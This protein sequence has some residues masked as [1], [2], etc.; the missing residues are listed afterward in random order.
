MSAWSQLNVASTGVDYTIDFNST[1][2]GVNEDH[3][4]GLGLQPSPTAGQLDSDAWEIIGFTYGSN[5]VV[6]DPCYYGDT[7]T[8]A[9]DFTREE[10]S[11]GVGS[12]GLYAF[13]GGSI[14]SSAIDRSLGF[15]PSQNNLEPGSIE[16]RC[17]NN[18]TEN[19]HTVDL[20]Y[21]IHVR[22]DQNRSNYLNALLVVDNMRTYTSLSA[23]NGEIAESALEYSSQVNG[24]PSIVFTQTN[25]NHSFSGVIIEPGEYFYIKWETGEIAGS[26]ERDEFAI[27]DIVI[28]VEGT[29]SLVFYTQNSG[30]QSNS[31]AASTSIEWSTL[32]AGNVRYTVF[33]FQDSATHV[34]QNNHTMTL[35]ASG[36]NFTIK[37]LVVEGLGRLQGNGDGSTATSNFLSLHKNIVCDGK[38]GFAGGANSNIGFNFLP[39]DHVISGNGVFNCSRI[40]KVADQIG[41]CNLTFGMDAV[42]HWS[43]TGMFNDRDALDGGDNLFNISIAS[44]SHVD[45]RG[46]LSID[47]TNP[48]LGTGHDAGGH[49]MVDGILTVGKRLYATNNNS[50]AFVPSSL[51]INTGGVVNVNEIYAN[52]SAAAGHTLTINGGGLLNI[53]GADTLNKAWPNFSLTNNTIDLQAGST[54]EYSRSGN[55]VL[56]NSLVYRN[57]VLS[58]SGDKTLSATIAGPLRVH[59]DLS[60][61]G[62]AIL[63]PAGEDI[64]IH[65]SG[66]WSS[67]GEGG[68]NEGTVLVK[69]DNPS[70]ATDTNFINTVGGEIFYDLEIP[71]SIGMLALESNVT[72]SNSFELCSILALNSNNLSIQ[73]LPI[74][75]GPSDEA[76]V[77]SEDV[78]HQGSMTVAVNAS[79][80]NIIFPFGTVSGEPIYCDFIR[81]PSSGSA[82]QVTMAT[83]PTDAA[84]EP[85]PL[86]PEPV[87]N[88]FSTTGLTPDNGEATVDRFWSITSTGTSVDALISINFLQSEM[89]NNAPFNDLSTIRAQRYETSNDKWQPSLPSQVVDTSSQS[90]SVYRITIPSVTEFGPWAAASS[91]SPLPVELLSF[92]GSVENG[93]VALEWSSASEINNSHFILSRFGEDGISKEIATVAGEG[94]SSS[95]V[96]YEW[97]D[98][99][100]LIGLNYYQLT[101][102]DFDGTA[103]DEGTIVVLWKVGSSL[104]V[105]QQNWTEDGLYLLTQS[106]SERLFL[107]IFDMNGRLIHEGTITAGPSVTAF[108]PNHSGIYVARLTD[109]DEILSIRIPFTAR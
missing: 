47:G 36:P 61:E 16:L 6:Q 87:N 31:L 96:N 27:D 92:K 98:S 103:T 26:G 49:I 48:A 44:G 58:G 9:G 94:N 107:E 11:G 18:T 20:S 56:P 10:S 12:G 19:I 24:T 102:V 85:K 30:I 86:F 50:D 73:T 32:P 105:L 23:T 29:D 46:Y 71:L 38:I 37:S 78:L 63:Q 17:L 4:R 79:T 60:I 70:S 77:I 53:T 84:N 7:K 35:A 39:G 95:V 67:W 25:M 66:N 90:S 14:G 74:I 104:A 68:F 45:V 65:V 88:L 28:S 21:E 8:A 13:Y 80:Q 99:E 76:M 59:E 106:R 41:I 81:N 69:L 75:T 109:G 52:A 34:I 43:A 2:S 40:R 101:Q 108:T 62:S 72:V 42:L 55:Q 1:V 82:G 93:G 51:T 5:P 33:P 91:N 54:V 89:P 97:L 3:F 100:P 83:Y 15:Q 57:L 64:D 22:D